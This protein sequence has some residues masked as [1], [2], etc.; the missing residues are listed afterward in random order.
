MKKTPI[1]IFFILVCVYLSFSHEEP[2]KTIKEKRAKEKERLSVQKSGIK[3]FTVWKHVIKNGVESPEGRSR[4]YT[5]FFDS[6]GNLSGISVFRNSDTLD[7]RV[8][9]KYD[10]DNSMLTDTDFDSV[11]LMEE[12]VSYE[13]DDQGKV[14]S[15]IN[16]TKGWV[17]DSKFKYTVDEKERTIIYE[18]FKPLD[19]L[20]YRIYY[21]YEGV[22]DSGKNVEILKRKPDGELLMRVVSVFDANN[23]R[24][25]KRIFNEKNELMYYFEYSYYKGGEKFSMIIKYSPENKV[26]SKTFYSLNEYGMISTVKTIDDTGDITSFSSYEYSKK[27]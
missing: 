25:Q 9:Y 8:E 1:I 4:H 16:Y 10:K 17:I 20:E 27:E 5:T 26:I 14:K 13:Y 7:Y 2:P 11:G 15:G 12:S 19:S 24:T 22:V 6:E 18:K 3:S 21:N 23:L